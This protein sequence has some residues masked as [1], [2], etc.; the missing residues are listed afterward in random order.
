MDVS[1]L[2]VVVW[3]RCRGPIRTCTRQRRDGHWTSTRAG[4]QG[5]ALRA[6]GLPAV[7]ARHSIN[8][9]PPSNASHPRGPHTQDAQC[10]AAGRGACCSAAV[11][12]CEGR[13]MTQ[14]QPAGTVEGQEGWQTSRRGRPNRGAFLTR[15]RASSGVWVIGVTEDGPCGFVPEL[16]MWTAGPASYPAGGLGDSGLNPKFPNRYGSATARDPD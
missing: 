14:T 12:V 5:R 7:M 8:P 16:K 9:T 13:R 4:E 10:N 1:K 15:T 6:L 3:I 2:L 11:G